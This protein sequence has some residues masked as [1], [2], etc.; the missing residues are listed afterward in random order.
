MSPNSL[1]PI[2]YMLCF[3]TTSRK[4]GDASR[5]WNQRRNFRRIAR[6]MNTLKCDQ[7]NMKNLLIDYIINL[8]ARVPAMTQLVDSE[9]LGWH[10]FGLWCNA[11][12]LRLQLCLNRQH[13]SKNKGRPTLFLYQDYHYFSLSC[14]VLPALRT[15]SG[16]TLAICTRLCSS[17]PQE[18][19]GDCIGWP[20]TPASSP[21]WQRSPAA[22]TKEY[23]NKKFTLST[24]V[25]I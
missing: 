21:S 2:P 4:Y 9:F 3:M 19:A 12:V 13:P 5:Q 23:M 10:Q 25:L 24:P 15:F 22:F 6:A 1:K 17:G 16:S 7:S 20:D 18:E 11:L 8:H 14:F